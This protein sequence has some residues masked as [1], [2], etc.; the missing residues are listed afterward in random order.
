M[1]KSISKEERNLVFEKYEGK[2][3]YCGIE[4]KKGWHVD[5]IVP[6]V[7]GGKDEFSNYNPSCKECNTY[8]GATR[9]ETYRSQ[10]KRML[11]ERLEYLFKSKTKMK[12]AMNMGSI[13]YYEWD[14]LFYFERIKKICI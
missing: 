3:A 11:I 5:H 7:F 8:K 9:L 14:E 6:F 10:L 13:V 12:V 1:R 2:C 4:L